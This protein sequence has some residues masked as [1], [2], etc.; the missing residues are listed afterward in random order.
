MHRLTGDGNKNTLVAPLWSG[1]K[2][3]VLNSINRI[4]SLTEGHKGYVFRK[5]EKDEIPLMFSIILSRMKWMDKVG[6]NQWNKTFYD[7]VYPMEYYEA[8]RKSGEVFVLEKASS[9]EIV[10]AAVL[11]NDDER[12]EHIDDYREKSA[13]YLHNFCSDEKHKGAGSV[14]LDFAEEYG[15]IAGKDVFRLDSAD[16]NKA[17]ENYY[18]K[19]G[20]SPK[21]FCV[22]GLYK[23]I[24]REKNIR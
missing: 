7:E 9:G 24:L 6:I 8:H 21:G 2:K 16:D 5:I 23:G 15:R 17:L 20:Y 4:I 10:A 1:N 22:D 11:R 19:R 3:D 13:F 12:W 18:E 14:F